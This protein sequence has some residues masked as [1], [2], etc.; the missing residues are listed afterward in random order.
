MPVQLPFALKEEPRDVALNRAI[1]SAAKK[2]HQERASFQAR[3]ADQ[4][5]E[6]G[7]VKPCT[8]WKLC[9]AKDILRE[10]VQD[11]IAAAKACHIASRCI[12]EL[13][14]S[15]ENTRKEMEAHKERSR[16]CRERFHSAGN[17]IFATR[18]LEEQLKGLRAA[19]SEW[20]D[21]AHSMTLKTKWV[22]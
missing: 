22:D 20:W 9:K 13:Q 21:L 11:I 10:A 8:L 14:E 4:K 7:N 6:F 2:R 3:M 16:R 12:H 18:A 1:L 19:E 15:A 5:D 17:K